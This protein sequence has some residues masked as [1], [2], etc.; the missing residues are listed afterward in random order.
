MLT[1]LLPYNFP[2]NF[3]SSTSGIWQ[4]RWIRW[5][6]WIR[7]LW[8]GSEFTFCPW[9]LH[10]DIELCFD[11]VFS[12]RVGISSI[13]LRSSIFTFCSS[14]RVVLSWV[15][16]YLTIVSRSIFSCSIFSRSKA[17][18]V[19]K[20]I[21]LIYY[22]NAN[23]SLIFLRSSWVAAVPPISRSLAN[24]I[25]SLSAILVATPALSGTSYV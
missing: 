19:S 4:W 10:F 12:V 22:L 24:Q 25:L 13:F 5:I 14:I 21:S 18:I 17:L 1:T 16:I 2:Y 3:L 23:V 8:S 7:W 9:F 11:R 15:K 6:R 20:W